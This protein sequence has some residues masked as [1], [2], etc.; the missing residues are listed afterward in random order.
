MKKNFYTFLPILGFLICLW[1][2][3]QEKPASLGA[4]TQVVET[5]LEH[6]HLSPHIQPSIPPDAVKSNETWVINRSAGLTLPPRPDPDAADFHGD[7]VI[8]YRHQLRTSG[9]PILLGEGHE[10]RNYRLYVNS[11]LVKPYLLSVTYPR[12]GNDGIQTS[13]GF[14]FIKNE[15]PVTKIGVIIPEVRTPEDMGPGA[16]DLLE[17]QILIGA[18]SESGPY[19]VPVTKAKPQSLGPSVVLLMATH[20]DKIPASSPV[21]WFKFEKNGTVSLEND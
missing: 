13:G 2:L 10:R 6:T 12:W 19:V 15:N 8:L 7:D 21:I 20:P 18:L 4:E 1:L 3:K 9:N 14:V 11:P 5:T 16:A 17:W